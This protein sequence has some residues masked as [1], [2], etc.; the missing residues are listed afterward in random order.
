[1][2]QDVFAE[3][4]RA[5]KTELYEALQIDHSEVIE[6][7]I[8]VA[9]D[10][11]VHGNK[12]A[13]V[14]NSNRLGLLLRDLSEL[15]VVNTTAYRSLRRDLRNAKD[16]LGS[17]HGTRFEVSVAA[18]LCLRKV[19]FAKQERPDFKIERGSARQRAQT[20]IRI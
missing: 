15:A 10:A 11:S 14:F 5:Q 3:T 7:Q 4:L 17:F 12:L 20:T 1:M 16:D 8:D 13:A 2:K 6:N 9:V 19:D 18:Q